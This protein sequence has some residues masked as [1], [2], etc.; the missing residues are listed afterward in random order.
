MVQHLSARCSQLPG[1]SYDTVA[2]T[3]E[4]WLR[5]YTARWDKFGLSNAGKTVAPFWGEM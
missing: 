5:G 3:D 1:D 4:D 2:E